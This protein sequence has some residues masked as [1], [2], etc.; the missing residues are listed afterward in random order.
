MLTVVSQHELFMDYAPQ[1]AFE[2]NPSELL[3][4]ALKRGFVTKVGHDQYL[5]N[6]AY[7]Q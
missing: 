6:E 4:E 5:I 1:F 7:S 3:A 2:L